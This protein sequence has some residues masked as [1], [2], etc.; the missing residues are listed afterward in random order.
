MHPDGE[1]YIASLFS[2]DGNSMLEGVSRKKANNDNNKYQ[3]VI[4]NTK[5]H[6]GNVIKLPIDHIEK[7]LLY[8]CV[9]RSNS[10]EYYLVGWNRLVGK[11]QPLLLKLK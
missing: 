3:W 11:Y 6:L 1:A 10:G 5:L 4:Y 9:T 7:P 2:I 8:G